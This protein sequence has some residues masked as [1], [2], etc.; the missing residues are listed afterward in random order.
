[1]LFDHRDFVHT[2]LHLSPLLGGSR[3]I[4]AILFVMGKLEGWGYP[5]VKKL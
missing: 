1:M 4:I 5:M 3:R 2:P